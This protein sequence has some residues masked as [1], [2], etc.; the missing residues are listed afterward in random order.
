MSLK[1]AAQEY[2]DSRPDFHSGSNTECLGCALA[3]ELR[4]PQLIYVVA[5]FKNIPG[6]PIL[7]FG[8]FDEYVYTDK[9]RA[10]A[11]AKDLGWTVFEFE[12][13]EET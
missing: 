12:V 10:D 9:N 2:L 11:I 3:R 5:N 8:G 13:S 1:K 4:K 7:I 6:S